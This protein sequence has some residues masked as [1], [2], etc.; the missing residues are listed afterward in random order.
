MLQVDINPAKKNFLIS[1]S[2]FLVQKVRQIGGQHRDLM[3]IGHELVGKRVI[4]HADPAVIIART[5]R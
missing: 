3:P 4:P 1:T 2:R 5:G